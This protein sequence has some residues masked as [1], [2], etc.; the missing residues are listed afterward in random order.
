MRWKNS[1]KQVEMSKRFTSDEDEMVKKFLWIPKRIDGEVRWLETAQ[2]RRTPWP[3]F[4]LLG[5]K[6]R[7]LYFSWV[8]REGS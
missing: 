7:W 8:D 6:F 1:K 5:T 4:S 2:M 3:T